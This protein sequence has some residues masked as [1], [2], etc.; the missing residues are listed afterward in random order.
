MGS[1]EQSDHLKGEIEIDAFESI[2]TRHIGDSSYPLLNHSRLNLCVDRLHDACLGKK[3]RQPID[4][5]RRN[6]SRAAESQL[7]TET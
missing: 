7:W 2:R 5:L 4:T 1:V 6:I 3:V